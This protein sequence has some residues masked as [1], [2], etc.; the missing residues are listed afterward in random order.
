MSTFTEALRSMIKHCKIW[1]KDI[2]DPVIFV[3]VD[4]QHAL[5]MPYLSANVFFAVRKTKLSYGFRRPKITTHN[6]LCWMDYYHVV[7][8]GS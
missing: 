5:L 8:V 3:A 2:S 7:L 1:F 6:I 4:T